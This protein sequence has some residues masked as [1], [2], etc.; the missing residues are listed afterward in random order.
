MNKRLFF[1]AMMIVSG[2]CLAQEGPLNQEPINTGELFGYMAED[3]EADA[4]AALSAQNCYIYELLE[5]NQ[6][7]CPPEYGGGYYTGCTNNP[8]D[9]STIRCWYYSPTYGNFFDVRSCGKASAEQTTED[10][11]SAKGIVEKA[12]AE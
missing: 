6:C 10:M 1:V 8:P 11:E 9:C 7:C 5:D 12:S 2:F 3:G 4:S